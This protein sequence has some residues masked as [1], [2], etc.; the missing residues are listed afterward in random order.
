MKIVAMPLIP[1][2]LLDISAFER[3]RGSAL[4]C[5]LTYAKY[6]QV[7][8][9]WWCKRNGAHF[10]AISNRLGGPEYS[11]VLPTFQKWLAPEYLIKE[12]GR[13][14]KIAVVDADTMIR[15]DTPDFF[16][17]AGQN[18]AA[19]ACAGI[20][21]GYRGISRA[22]RA[23]PNSRSAASRG[24]APVGG[25][26][27]WISRSLLAFKPM[28]PNV[29][30]PRKEYFNSGFVVLGERQLSV[31]RTFLEFCLRHWSELTEIMAM[32]TVGTDQTPLNFIVRRENEVVRFLPSAFNLINCFPMDQILLEIEEDSTP[33]WD[34]FARRAF[35]RPE[36]FDFVYRGYIWH[37]TNVLASRRLVMEETWRIVR[38]HYPGSD[39]V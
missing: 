5:N 31:L 21:D 22:R 33:N 27:S 17:L 37:F 35:G 39:D 29:A 13:D 16:S 19:V 24:P 32:R 14:C 28:F 26:E 15:W 4:R 25:K 3:Y 34:S 8:W 11:H 9:K 7:T 1:S 36:N 10:I 38:G 23:P 2:T 12:Y 18:F 30:L 6:S 20:P